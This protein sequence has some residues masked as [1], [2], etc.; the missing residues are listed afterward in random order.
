MAISAFQSEIDPDGQARARQE[1]RRQQQQMEAARLN[2]MLSN[3]TDSSLA[4]QSSGTGLPPL[5]VI[6]KFMD[7][8]I[9]A[10]TSSTG[11]TAGNGAAGADSGGFLSSL[12]NMFGGSGGGASSGGAGSSGGSAAMMNPYTAIAALVLAGKTAEYKN[13]GEWYSDASLSLLGPSLGQMREDPKLGLTTLLGL[14]FLNGF[15][16]NDDA[17]SAAPEWGAFLD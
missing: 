12:G 11:A 8:G 9:G 2:S 17:K 4:D 14:P 16:A 10:G 15:I 1:A 6:Q 3:R 5:S 13:P 7:K